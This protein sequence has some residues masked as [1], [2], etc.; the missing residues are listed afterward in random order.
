[1]LR[2]ATPIPRLRA[3]PT[4]QV[5]VRPW[6]PARRGSVAR[7]RLVRALAAAS[8]ADLAV[9]VAPAG[10]GKTSLLAEW[11]A[12]DARP[13]AWLP[14]GDDDNDPA[15][16]L[17]AIGG[18]LEEIAP[19]HG[20]LPGALPLS[21]PVVLVLDDAHV[22]QAPAA[23]EAVAAVA[24]R[25]GPGSLVAL[26]SRS[27]PGL[28][29]GRLRAHGALVEL[30]AKDLAM[31][32]REAAA[33]LRRA[34]TPL[35]GAP[36][37]AVMRATEGWPAALYLA[38]LALREE[39]D[40]G[41]AAAR[42]RGDD[43]L[44]ADYLRDELLA[45]LDTEAI[46]FLT[47]TS[48]LEELSGPLCDAVLGRRGSGRI[49]R[50]LSRSALPLR[51]LDRCDERFRTH[52][53]LAAMLRGELR[54]QE[55]DGEQELQRRASAWHERHG[56]VK[57]AIDHAVAAG[58]ASRAAALLW[59]GVTTGA[60]PADG[61]A[62]GRRL[63]RLGDDRVAREPAAAAT[64]A[65]HHLGR[66]DRDSA[67]RWADAAERVLG[68]G[69]GEPGL[70]AGLALVR[71]GVARHGVARMGE[72]A[73]AADAL[74]HGDEPWL[75]STRLLAGAAH[76]LTGDR[77]RAPAELE[78]GARRAGAR[79]PI[80][81]AL[82][83]AQQA[84]LALEA[85][86]WEQGARLADR[87]LEVAGTDRAQAA[88][89]ALYAVAAFARSHGG[90][91]DEA[92]AAAVV[93]RRHLAT[94]DGLPP[95]LEAEAR[96]ALARAELRLSD[97]AAARALLAEAS[98]ALRRCPDAVVL[99]GWIDDA[100]VR[101]D[102]FAAAAVTGPATLTRAELRV[103]RFLPSH[104][105]FPEIAERLHVSGNTVKTQAHAVYRKLDASSRSKA[106][107]RARAVGLIDG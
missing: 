45:P 58:D 19:L 86:D 74:A 28:P 104:L 97:A 84:L 40:P 35:V 26:A 105:S 44:V 102:A 52:P 47:R 62:V 96:V 99:R 72:D 90:R 88:L 48:A 100:W 29:L 60:L 33:L 17:T 23:L 103:L 101:A 6:R 93:A 15:E 71:A 12:A 27:E 78:E 63:E 65:L 87:A 22:L 68:D 14:L 38:A 1:M 107:A 92:R 85:E 20:D 42:F 21:R 41:R 76:H 94:Q 34:G 43:R 98:R 30:R 64:A 67:E 91:V 70:R 83:L 3:L 56:D 53:L 32:E 39:D 57:R 61:A 25:L 75:A 8:D 50:D 11:A 77:D 95:W 55:P 10:Y 51:P 81:H 82:C 89:A 73:D 54:R 13:F 16:L 2:Q 24:E 7:P 59:R 36:L 66:G 79:V 69:A 18:R 46:D 37:A 4:P 9:L 5:P 80:I 31:T 49:L 106:V